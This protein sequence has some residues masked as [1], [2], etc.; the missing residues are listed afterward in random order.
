MKAAL[1]IS[2]TWHDLGEV[3]TW[4]DE[5]GW[6]VVIS[7]EIP[8]DIWVHVSMIDAEGRE[9]LTP[10]ESVVIEA[11]GPLEDDQDGYDYRGIRV[12]PYSF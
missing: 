6:G 4:N 11:E 2:S 7:S 10:G 12:T 8:S 1:G 3:K 5:E 9:T